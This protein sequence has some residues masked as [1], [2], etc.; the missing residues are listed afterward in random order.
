M[1][2]LAGMSKF[3]LGFRTR[4]HGKITAR[5]RSY[6]TTTGSVLQNACLKSSST[7]LQQSVLMTNTLSESAYTTFGTETSKQ[8]CSGSVHQWLQ[9]RHLLTP[10]RG[11]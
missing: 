7:V 8:A 2:R 5:G 10:T 4:E 9:R 11:L 3:S 6:A 1:R